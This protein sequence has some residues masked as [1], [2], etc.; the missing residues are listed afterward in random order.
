[1]AGYVHVYTG[2]GKGKTTAAL[3]LALRA[4]GAGWRVFIGQFAKAAASSEL[5][6]LAR[7]S[8]LITICQFGRPGWIGPKPSPEDMV[9]AREG[10]ERCRQAI[11]SGQYQLVILDEV[12]LGPVLRLF[13]LE[14]LLALIDGRPD[15]VELVLTGRYAPP[16]IL[17]RADVVTEMR[18]LK[19]YYRQGV[20]ARTGIEM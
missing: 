13:S 17:E 5:R 15:G 16:A 7:L 3:G 11:A 9:A 20:L 18:E 12:I 4:A 19:H 8:D 10:L 6:A 14:E 1:M 2:D